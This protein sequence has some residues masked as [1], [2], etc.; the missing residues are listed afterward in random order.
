MR[1]CFRRRRAARARRRRG[2]TARSRRRATRLEAGEAAQ[3]RRLA[4]ARRAEQAADLALGQ[5]EVEAAH[6]GVRAVGVLEL[7]DVDRGCHGR[8]CTRAS[9]A[10]AACD[11][12]VRRC[13]ARRAACR[14][15]APSACR[16]SPGRRRSA[17][18][19]AA[20]SRRPRA[21]G[22]A[23]AARPRTPASSESDLRE[24]L[25]EQRLA[26]DRRVAAVAAAERRAVRCRRGEHQRVVVLRAHR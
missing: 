3:H 4:A 12:C 25:L 22:H 18:W 17:D 16:P 5:R 11:G 23:L 8:E 20:A 1:R 14:G 7:A 21:L 15:R 9:V 6:D 26:E 13:A 2:P 24:P 19:T 10:R